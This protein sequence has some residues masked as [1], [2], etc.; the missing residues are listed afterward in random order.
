MSIPL[1]Q[2]VIMAAATGNEDAYKA[3]LKASIYNKA[4]GHFS[5]FPC[6]CDKADHGIPTAEQAEQFNV[7]LAEDLKDYP[8]PSY[9]TGVQGPPGIQGEKLT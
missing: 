3:V 9:T 4:C 2:C 8:G 5:I 1:S 7:R 6:E